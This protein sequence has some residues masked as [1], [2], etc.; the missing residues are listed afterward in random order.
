MLLYIKGGKY[1][2]EKKVPSILGIFQATTNLWRKED[3]IFMDENQKRKNIYPNR[4]I[5]SKIIEANGIKEFKP[6]VNRL[7]FI[8]NKQRWGLTFWGR[9]MIEINENDYQIIEQ[10]LLSK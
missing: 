9:S 10:Y 7:A 5:I 2:N 3:D 8:K 6:L 1:A 4:I